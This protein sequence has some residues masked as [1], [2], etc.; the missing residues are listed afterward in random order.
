MTTQTQSLVADL[1]ML[2]SGSVDEVITLSTNGPWKTKSGGDLSVLFSFDSYL[3]SNFFDYSR[4]E[5]EKLPE[6][7]RGL[8]SYRVSNI[9]KG[10]VGGLEFHRVRSEILYGLEGQVRLNCEDVYGG[11]RTLQINEKNGVLLPPFILH[12]YTA[13]QKSDLLVFCNTIFPPEKEQ[14]HDTYSKDVFQELQKKYRLLDL[15]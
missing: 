10:K 1:P 6:D 5:L 12:T 3:F 9:E 2:P 4:N 7:I 15:V 11:R 13:E 14:L 8:R